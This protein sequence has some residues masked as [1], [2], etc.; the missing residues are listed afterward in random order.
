[1][2]GGAH[3]IPFASEFDQVQTLAYQPK[4]RSGRGGPPD[5]SGSSSDDVRRRRRK[6]M[7]VHP[8]TLLKAVVV[9]AKQ[10]RTMVLSF[11]PRVRPPLKERLLEL[12][13]S[14]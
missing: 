10:A 4:V 8:I 11:H 12:S 2:I 14:P 3:Q 6:Y 9:G 13:S 5:S 7:A 1:V